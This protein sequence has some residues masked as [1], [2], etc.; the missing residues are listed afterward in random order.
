MLRVS[1]HYNLTINEVVMYEQED[2]PEITQIYQ[3][4]MNR[5]HERPGI[6]RTMGKEVVIQ[7]L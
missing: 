2:P 4:V 1:S 7:V 6:V 3:I 5:T